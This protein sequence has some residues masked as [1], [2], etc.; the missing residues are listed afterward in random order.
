MDSSLFSA[1]ADGSPVPT[2]GSPVPTDGFVKS[3][4]F[5]CDETAV[6]KFVD[7]DIVDPEEKIETKIESIFKRSDFPFVFPHM[8]HTSRKA[9]IEKRATLGNGGQASNQHA[10]N[11]SSNG[12]NWKARVTEHVGKEWRRRQ[13]FE[14]YMEMEGADSVGKIGAGRNCRKQVR[15]EGKFLKQAFDGNCFDM[16][17]SRDVHDVVEVDRH[18]DN[19]HD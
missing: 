10:S 2:D 16:C 8:S 12:G 13:R 6:L 5:S 11:A 1:P 9:I 18:I 3:C 7:H 4:D 14:G 19:A 15:F 17:C